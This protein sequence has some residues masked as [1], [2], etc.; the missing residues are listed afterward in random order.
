MVY[1]EGEEAADIDEENYRSLSDMKTRIHNKDV[2][3]NKSRDSL[4]SFQERL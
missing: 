3:V 4:A 1:Y 2:E